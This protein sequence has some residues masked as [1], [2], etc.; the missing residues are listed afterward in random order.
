MVERL[1]VVL[2]L[3]GL[4][5]LIFLAFTWYQRRRIEEASRHDTDRSAAS[6]DISQQSDG[7]PRVLYFRSDHCV[8]C[9]TQ[10]RLWEDLEPSVRRLIE[11]ID[12][13]RERE[14]AKAYNVM[15]LPT[16]VVVDAEGDV[17]HINYGVVPP[18]K[19]YAQLSRE[20]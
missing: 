9:E 4:G 19:L 12:V 2:G 3:A 15:T 18:K 17:K 16:T 11:R 7:R 8:S 1:L 13:D 5:G 20:S 14:R 10:A 6:A